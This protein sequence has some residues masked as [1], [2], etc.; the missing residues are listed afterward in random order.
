MESSYSR[1]LFR[2]RSL[3][4]AAGLTLRQ[5]E[6][7]SRGKWKAVVVGSYERGTRHLSLMRAVELCDFYG[8]D[9]SDLGNSKS[10]TSIEQV[11][12]DLRQISQARSLPDELS[13]VISRT[14]SRISNLRGDLNGQ[15]L[16]IRQ[17]DL[18]NLQIVCDMNRSELL[19]ALQIRKFLFGNKAEK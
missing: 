6:I 11:I 14:A 3:R 7:K 17:S 19:A 9:I 15:V 5:L 1:S 12:F 4:L 2:L 10:D 16:S 13:R 18:D 8:A